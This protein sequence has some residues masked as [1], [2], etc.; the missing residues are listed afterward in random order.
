MILRSI[1]NYIDLLHVRC[2]KNQYELI[3]VRLIGSRSGGRDL[4]SLPSLC[5]PRLGCIVKGVDANLWPI[6]G[7][8]HVHLG[9]H[10]ENTIKQRCRGSCDTCQH[11]HLFD[12]KIFKVIN[13]I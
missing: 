1:E 7:I 5:W 2:V 11:N 10:S 3:T 6:G 4:A 13:Y 12:S 8:Q 9:K